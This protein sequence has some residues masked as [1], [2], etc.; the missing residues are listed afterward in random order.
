MRTDDLTNATRAH[1]PRLF[2]GNLVLDSAVPTK[3]FNLCA[4]KDE[5][6]FS[7]MH[8]SAATSDPNDFKDSSSPSPP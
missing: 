8:Y 2:Y 1:D 4:H 7:H 3:L 6:E 5:R